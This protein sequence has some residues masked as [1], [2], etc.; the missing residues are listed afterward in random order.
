[1]ISYEFDLRYDPAVIQPA[2]EPVDAAG[3]VSRGLTFVTNDKAP[4]L[5]RVV[6]YGAYHRAEDGLLLNLRFTVVG[7]PDSSSRLHWDRQMFNEGDPQVN[8][9]D[10]RIMISTAK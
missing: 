9:S 10:G 6:I 8:L 4:G 1:M 3:S 7:A 2:A 5:L